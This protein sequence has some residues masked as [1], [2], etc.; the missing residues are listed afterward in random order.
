VNEQ[1]LNGL[2][3]LIFFT[4]IFYTERYLKLF[5]WQKNETFPSFFLQ[6]NRNFNM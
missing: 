1:K 2:E 5:E 3:Q 6:R 4:G